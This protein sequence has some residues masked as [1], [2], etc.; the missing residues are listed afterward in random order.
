MPATL[1]RPMLRSPVMRLAGRRFES[2]ATGKAAEAAKETASKA[3]Q[4]LSKVGSA[5]AGAAKGLG[6][7]LSKAGGRT[8]RLISFVERQTPFVVYYSRVG[9]E[10]SKLV[11]QGQK[12][13]FPSL[14]TFQ[15][16]YQ[17]L[18][19]GLRSGSLIASPQQLLQ[20][21]RSIGAPQLAAGGVILAECLGFFTVGEM[22]GR[23]KLVGYHGETAHH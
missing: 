1:I 16:F 5:A 7:A 9:L 18:W 8:G 14:A 19:T 6:N 13:A 15:S 23:F 2:T 10:L 20:Q 11:F 12:I 17:S 3:Q 22:V 21:V 4:G